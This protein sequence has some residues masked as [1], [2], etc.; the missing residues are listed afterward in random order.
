VAD[1][2][3][4]D[5]LPDAVAASHATAAT[6]LRGTYRTGQLNGLPSLR[7]D[8]VDDAYTIPDIGPVATFDVWFLGRFSDLV[9]RT[10]LGKG[11]SPGSG[12]YLRLTNATSVLMTNDANVGTAITV[13]AITTDYALYH[14][15]ANAGTFAIYRNGV[16]LGSKAMPA[17]STVT[18]NRI[19]RKPGST[20]HYFFGD[21]VQLLMDTSGLSLSA[22]AG[23]SAYLM[24][25]GGLT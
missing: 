22:A 10:L 19:G 13:P 2:G 12:A 20:A 16:L 4:V 6:T 8:G 5:T 14:F 18:F 9:N 11:V 17:D 25:R 1:G 21:I 3:S 7:F 23:V 15:R 24:A